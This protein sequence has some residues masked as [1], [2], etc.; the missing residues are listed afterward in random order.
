MC[1]TIGGASLPTKAHAQT[2]DRY[3]YE[4]TAVNNKSNVSTV[5]HIF[6]ADERA[7][8]ENVVANGWRIIHI[9]QVSYKVV[10]SIDL[11]NFDGDTDNS[12]LGLN[13][14][15]VITDPALTNEELINSI[16]G[17]PQVS[18]PPVA[19]TPPSTEPLQSSPNV[20]A[21]SN[22]PR[23]EDL[24][25]RLTIYFD[26][27]LNTPI[28]TD[29]VKVAIEKLD[30]TGAYFLFANTDNVSVIP[31]NK[32]YR[33]NYQLSVQ[34]GNSVKSLMVK[35]GINPAN[36]HIVGLGALYPEVPNA[37]SLGGTPKNRRVV[38]YGHKTGA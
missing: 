16:M 35:S 14:P 1:L 3:I 11:G 28:I 4:I 18:V 29:E 2:H 13:E 22:V 31:K 6:A 37:N 38:I 30:K 19:A 24:E 25:Y 34:R 26:F 20:A 15:L 5:M 7:A 27:A 12:S 36:I 17:T 21:T 9:R 33:D 23:P 10:D 8:R 32:K